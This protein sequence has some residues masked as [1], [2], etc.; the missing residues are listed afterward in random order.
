M[1]DLEAAPLAR[2]HIVDQLIYERAP[3]LV[4]STLWPMVR[5]LLYEILGYR[6]ARRMADAIA[7]MGGVEALD[8]VANLLQVRVTLNHPERLPTTG[9][10]VIVA[11]HPSGIADGVS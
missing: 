10:V 8:H 7:S 5:P 11:N 1:T 3:Q 9:R 6:K 4:Q 2:G